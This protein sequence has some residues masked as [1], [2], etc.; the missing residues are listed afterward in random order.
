MPNS[1]R[2]C[3]AMLLAAAASIAAENRFSIADVMS[4]PF[5]S[6][7]VAAPSGA[8]AA[9]IENE[10]G[11]RNIWVARGP[12]WKAQRVTNFDRDDGQEIDDLAWAPDG[13]YLLFARGGD[14]E[15]GGENPNPDLDPKKPQQEIWRT[16]LDG[17]APVKLV[18]GRAPQI[19]SKGMVVFLRHDQIYLLSNADGKS[20]KPEAAALVEQKGSQA[21][22]RWSRDGQRLAF[23]SE[24]G[25]HSFIGVYSVFDRKLVY[26]DPSVD[27]DSEPS[28]SPDGEQIAFLRI[29]AQARE[30]F[31]SPRRSGPP[32]SIRLADVKTG[33]G[34]EVFRAQE[35]TGSLFHGVV[36]RQQIFWSGD[37]LVFPWE[38]TGWNHLYA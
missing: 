21:D 30:A 29:P 8:A 22:L 32:W 7:L 15:N 2:I 26:L 20:G 11:R 27:R 23:V 14:F 9:W 38:R 18:E 16:A 24:R 3:A 31:F 6:G 5:A 34:R 33:N 4:G 12:D 10:Q 17:S 28:W 19:S 25:G 35:G 37:G 1:L 13:S 36:A